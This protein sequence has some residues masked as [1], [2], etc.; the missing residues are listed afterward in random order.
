MFNSLLGRFSKELGIDLG[1][2]NTVIYVKDRGIAI[3][4]PSII[5]INRK[6]EQILAVGREAREM[7]GKTPPHIEICRPLFRGVISDFEVTEKMLRFF[8]D[9][10]HEGGFNLM[11]RPRVVI[12]VPLEITEVERKA[13][14]DATLSAG[15]R[16]VFLV[17]E[18][19][20]SAVG[21]RLSIEEADG[22]MIVDIGGG[23]TQIA[24]ISL[25]GI[26]TWKSLAIAGDELNKNIIKYTKDVFGLLLGDRKSVV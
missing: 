25:S 17:E 4:E 10:V 19:I 18:P 21:A 3:N 13:I 24:V 9:K 20:A 8:I 5:A 14:E 6:T 26:V 22:N 11:P 7:V 15:A 1:T 16:E 23:A 2:S 12:G